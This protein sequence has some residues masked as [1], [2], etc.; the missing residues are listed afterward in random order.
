MRAFLS[1]TDTLLAIRNCCRK[2]KRIRAA[3][4]LI[5]IGG[6]RLIEEEL[7]YVLTRGGEVQLLL[8]IDMATEPEA[9]EALL[10]LHNRHSERMAMRRFVTEPRQTFH[11][12]TWIFSFQSG[13]AAA[14]VGSSNLTLGGLAN[15]YEANVRIEGAG[16]VELER[17]FD[18][19]FDGG[20]AKRIDPLWLDSYRELWKQQR[21]A[22]IRLN[23]LQEK[24]RLI[25]T[26]S[27]VKTTAPTRILDHSFAFTGGIADWPRQSKL[28]PTVE[29]Y[30]GSV[31]EAAGVKKADCLVHGDILGDR[32]TTRK[33]RA[34]RR[35]G[36]D[37]IN[38]SEFFR[39]LEN[40]KRLRGRKRP[41][42]SARR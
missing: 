35:G 28:Y 22:W 24:A 7:E 23:R 20:R 5:T 1:E 4:A 42:R 19:L 12:K 14:I 27:T 15:N 40:E 17:F 29:R 16:V 8:G 9:I 25:R 39:I 3:L 41:H 13:R 33:L 38:Q 37:V 30:G 2:A 11:P 32:K 26:R 10:K 6:L 36:V 21:D 34:A 18:E 31:I